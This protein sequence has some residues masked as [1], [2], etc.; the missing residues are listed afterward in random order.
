[1]AKGLAILAC[2]GAPTQ[3]KAVYLVADGGGQLSESD[4]KAHPEIVVVHS[5]QELASEMKGQVAVWIDKNAVKRVDLNWL[6][7]EPQ[8]HYPPEVS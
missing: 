8:E 1:V 6:Q 5:Q 4:L 7:V 3:L 2:T